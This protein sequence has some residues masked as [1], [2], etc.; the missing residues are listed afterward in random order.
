MPNFDLYKPLIEISAAITECCKEPREDPGWK[1]KADLKKVARDLEHKLDQQCEALIDRTLDAWDPDEPL[2][3]FLCA[4]LNTIKQD[5]DAEWH[6]EI[7]NVKVRLARL[8][9][10]E[11]RKSPVR[12]KLERNGWWIAILLVVVVVLSVMMY[13][14]IDVSYPPET[15]EGVVQGSAALK[16]LARY[17]P[18]LGDGLKSIGV[19]KRLALWPV[20]PSREEIEYALE[21]MWSTIDVYDSMQ[22]NNKLCNANLMHSADNG[23]YEDELAI[24]MVVVDF[25]DTTGRVNNS[26]SGI[27]L[28]ERAY[29][30]HF[31][32]S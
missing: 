6:A 19:V 7:E 24:A 8:A 17:D 2:G 26:E 25:I 13:S 18:S 28:I 9:A 23:N 3:E 32:C 20:K 30:R 31:Y 14:K 1:R 29:K 27:R 10:N 22:E 4:E 15:S 5:T 21:F 12:R 11:S 16:K